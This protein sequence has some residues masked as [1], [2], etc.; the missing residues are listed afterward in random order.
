MMGRVMDGSYRVHAP[1]NF[2][3][4]LREPSY[5]LSNPLP[6]VPPPVFT[7]L[8]FQ[9]LTWT[10]FLN[11]PKGEGRSI[12]FE[13]SRSIWNTFRCRLTPRFARVS[14]G[15]PL[16]LWIIPV[17]VKSGRIDNGKLGLGIFWKEEEGMVCAIYC[18]KNID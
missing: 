14:P 1:L 10:T 3:S 16:F 4:W 17:I 11:R 13:G 8:S 15:N 9:R 12:N 5:T 7:S 6:P 18:C 2:S